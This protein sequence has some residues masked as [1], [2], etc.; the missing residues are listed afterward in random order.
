LWVFVCFLGWGWFGGCGGGGAAGGAGGGV[1]WGEGFDGEVWLWDLCV[2]WG[3]LGVRLSV[4]VGVG[5]CSLWVGVGFV[6]VFVVY[7]SIYWYSI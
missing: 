2:W 7:N 6:I 3:G 5:N 4:L 1:F